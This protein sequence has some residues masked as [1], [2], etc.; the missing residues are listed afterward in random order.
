VEGYR[1]SIASNNLG[2]HGRNQ[3]AVYADLDVRAWRRFS[4]SA[5]LREELY[6]NHHS[7]LSPG[8]SAGAWLSSKLKLRGSVNHAFRLPSYTELFYRDP[9]TRGNPDLHPE[10]AWSYE[11]G[12]DWHPTEKVT[13]STT[14]FH[15]RERDGI[16][17]ARASA[18]NLW[19]ASNIQRLNFTGIETAV[20]L[21]VFR[22]QELSFAYTAMH[23]QQEGLSGLQ[24]K[25]TGN[26]PTQNGVFAWQGVFPGNVVGR[27]R[28]GA[29]NRRSEDPYLL[30]DVSAARRFGRFSP[31]VQFANLT[32]SSYW[33]IPGV[34]MPGRSLLAGMEFVLARK[35]K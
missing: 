24:T 18:Q 33:E 22:A 31:Y 2:R 6:A 19:Q 17:Y 28:I 7:E 34:T 32:N 20:K 15:R 4:F 21:R 14:V 3:G 10:S 25:Y 26:Y 12:V 13:A 5:G 1:E 16:D 9:A 8:F 11:G 35:S 23:G 30:W 27:T 29:T